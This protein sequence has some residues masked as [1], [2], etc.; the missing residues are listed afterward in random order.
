MRIKLIRDRVLK[1][2]PNDKVLDFKK[3]Y[4]V[5]EYYK[6]GTVRIKTYNSDRFVHYYLMSKELYTPVDDIEEES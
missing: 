1:E 6:T 2:Y 4:N 3:S 5:E